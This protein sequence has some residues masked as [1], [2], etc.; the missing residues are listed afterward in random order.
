MM[1][2]LM[3]DYLRNEG[4]DQFDAWAKT[5]GKTTTNMEV[6]PEGGRMI[7]RTRFAEF[8]NAPELMNM[9]RLVAD[10]RT[11]E[12][13]NLPTP[14]IH[15]GGSEDVVVPA[16]RA[17][18]A[19]IAGIGE[20]A[21]AIRSGAIKDPSIDNMLKISS[22]ARK[23]SLD[24]RLVDPMAREDPGSKVNAAIK[25][26][27]R[28]YKEFD[29]HK[30]TQ[31]VFLDL[32]TPKAERGA[33]GRKKAE[34]EIANQG[35]DTPAPEPAAEEQPE[36][37]PPA[38]DEEDLDLYGDKEEKEPETVETAEEAAE[39]FTVYNQI[40]RKLV[41]AGIPNEEIAFIHDANSDDRKKQLFDDMASGAVRVLIGSTEKMGAGM[42]VQKR[43]IAL[44]HLDAPWRPSDV[45]QREGR[46]DRQGNMLWDEHQI[47][48]HIFRYM[49]EGSFDAFMWQTIVAKARPI[50]LLMNGDPSVRRIE[51]MG[52]VVASYEQAMALSSGNPLI[53]EKIILDQE[54]QKLEI[55][56]GGW[57][58][59]QATINQALGT[60]PAETKRAHDNIT[61]L[62]NDIAT[63]DG[64]LTLK[65]G[66]K[67]FSAQEI[68]KEG[69]DALI[70]A[71]DKV[72][73]IDKITPI[74][75]TYRGFKLQA[76]PASET[77]PTKKSKDGNHFYIRQHTVTGKALYLE[78]RPPDDYPAHAVAQRQE[79]APRELSAA[80]ALKIHT[81]WENPKDDSLAY[82]ARNIGYYTR[83][84]L[85]LMGE[86]G[87][88]AVHANYETPSGT[89]SSADSS[90]RG[91]EED[92][93]NV[94]A[95]LARLEK[96]KVELDSKK[97]KPF[98]DEQKLREKQVRQA[99][100]ASILGENKDDVQAV[101]EEDDA[102]DPLAALLKDPTSAMDPR[103]FPKQQIYVTSPS[104]EKESEKVHSINRWLG[105]QEV[106]RKN[107]D[108]RWTVIHQPT[109]TAIATFDDGVEAVAFARQAEKAKNWDYT[110]EKDR[111]E[112]VQ[113]AREFRRDQFKPPQETPA[114]SRERLVPKP[115]NAEEEARQAAGPMDNYTPRNQKLK[116]PEVTKG[117]KGWA[118]ADI[119]GT[120]Y[121]SDGLYLIAADIKPVAKADP[122]P[123]ASVERLLNGTGNE[124]P[125]A[126][127]AFSTIGTG[128]KATRL[129]WF[130]R[131]SP[132]DARHYDDVLKRY[133]DAVFLRDK[134]APRKILI[135]DVHGKRV[136]LALTFRGAPAPPPEVGKLF[137]DIK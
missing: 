120:I 135:N 21:D 26:I 53:K 17:L 63:R 88:Y 16:S 61:A 37:P 71:L 93:I 108:S 15:G 70:K 86:S 36:A 102:N 75:A 8:V 67:T 92:L 123:T 90:I 14:A 130:S 107:N 42:N 9:F 89:I 43:L 51:E 44:H 20:R 104:G 19:Y 119:N 56:R 11:K 121:S 33:K 126:P 74:D 118:Q 81:A 110:T 99:E 1:R 28:L 125:V 32:S 111:Y 10:I 2:Y 69:A 60:L 30:A 58:T 25:N 96:Q 4:M 50:T 65:V 46:I 38:D 49:T 79:L 115:L 137:D 66:G 12:Q 62:T 57:L 54:I 6:A 114:E 83:P 47:P 39:R 55:L 24:M 136:G 124:T 22:D 100:L 103:W 29:Q 128:A 132:M 5:F 94:K 35:T 64:D 95:N 45:E 40:R 59:E 106:K 133:P 7:A 77:F 48:V 27:I 52:P 23:A 13:L 129:I 73:T 85:R 116:V 78:V 68:R 87:S 3:P 127:V 82:A 84:N 117:S 122:L 80:D 134:N 34:D 113:W 98:R 109:G 76:S 105:L 18:K 31:L 112:T 97:G 91:W 101:G 72:G 41:A 131:D